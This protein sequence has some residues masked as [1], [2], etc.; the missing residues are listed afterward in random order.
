MPSIDAITT[1]VPPYEIDQPTARDFARALFSHRLDD[2]ERRLSLFDNTGIEQRYFSRPLDWFSEEHTLEEKNHAYIESATELGAEACRTLFETAG[3]TP[4]QI[5]YI[6]YINT[7]GL[8]TPSIDARLINVL[9]LRRDIRRTPIWGLGCAGGAAALS[10]AHHHALGHPDSRVLIVAVE[11]CGLTFM[12]DDFSKSNLVACA[13]FGEGAAAVLVS[14]DKI[15]RHGPEILATQSNFY[16]DSLD[17][18]G[19]N[20]QSRG[21]QVVFDRHIPDL[22]AENSAAELDVFLKQNH[23]TRESVGQYLYHPGGAKVLDA[24][25]R[26]YDAPEDLFRYSRETLRDYGNMSSVTV[27]FVLEKYLRSQE[28]RR[29]DH[30]V[31]SALGPGFCSESLLIRG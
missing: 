12:P 4:D 1:A 5:D 11:L 7:T 15:E 20:I 19:W 8:A 30:A 25:R 6:V 29:D 27:L 13:L 18:M 22:V 23:L 21:L 14:G 17:V 3:L 24:Y 10:H 31:I 9:K 16:P 28:K 2:L 26:A